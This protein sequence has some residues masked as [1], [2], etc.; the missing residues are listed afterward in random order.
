MKL[1]RKPS[2]YAFDPHNIISN[3]E[4]LGKRIKVE[5]DALGSIEQKE[6]TDDG[7]FSK[8]IFGDTE[9]TEVDYSCE[10][11]NL[12]GK[13]YEGVTCEKCGTK[14]ERVQPNIN[15]MGWV[16]LTGATYSEDGAVIDPGHDYKIIKYVAYLFLEKI[17]GHE[18]LKNIIYV[19]DMIT[20]TGELDQAS[21]DAVRSSSPDKKYWFYG[22]SAF[23]KNYT[24]I[25]DYYYK[26]NKIEDTNLY[27]FVASPYDTFTDK[28]PVISPLLRPA[29]RTA[30]G[31]KL[32]KINNLYIRIITSVKRLTETANIL[33]IIKNSTLEMIQADYFALNQYIFDLIRSKEGLIRSQICGVRLN[34]TARSI[35]TPAFQGKKLDEITVPYLTFLEIYKFELINIIKKVK[36]ITYAEAEQIQFEAGIKFNQEVYD[37][38]CKVIKDNEIGVLLNRN[39]TIEVGSIIYLRITAVKDDINDLT[40]SVNNTILSLLSGDYDGDVVNLIS[41]KDK[42][43]QNIFKACLS[44]ISLIIN[45]EDGKFNDDL[46]MEKDQVIGLNTLLI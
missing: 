46:N 40:F 37:I 35:I 14:V 11:G 20:A 42:E 17:I 33:E 26:L 36:N 30:D 2:A 13:F 22:I 18:N 27:N 8:K 41:L 15:K 12:R 32:D 16:D 7:L 43:T 39:P 38:M 25:L 21:V 34:Y 23:E 4:I 19:P 29:I 45:P 31:L 28:I 44:P 6:F 3:P 9:N 24:E 5:D 1:I 10:C